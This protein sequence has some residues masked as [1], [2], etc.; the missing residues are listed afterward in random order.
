MGHVV[1]KKTRREEGRK[2][3][4]TS[5]KWRKDRVSRINSTKKRQGRT[6]RKER[7]EGKKMGKSW[8]AG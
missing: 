1:S 7:G 6:K 2:Q 4:Q 3:K 5:R 8:I